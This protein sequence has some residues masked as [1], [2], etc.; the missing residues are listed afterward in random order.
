MAQIEESAF[1]LLDSVLC[2]DSRSGCSRDSSHP[3]RLGHSYGSGSERFLDHLVLC[4]G[5]I[6]SAMAALPLS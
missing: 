6:R 1:A 4:L 3:G 2:V 5:C